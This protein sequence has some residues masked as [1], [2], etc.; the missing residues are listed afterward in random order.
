MAVVQSMDLT[1]IETA[2]LRLAIAKDDPSVRRAIDLYRVTQSESALK[3]ALLNVARETI[4]STLE[5]NDEED[6][7]EDEE[8][9]DEEDDNEEDSA[10][11]E[12]EEPEPESR[13]YSS[14]SKATGSPIKSSPV[15]VTTSPSKTTGSPA[16]HSTPVPKT[17]PLYKDFDY[18]QAED[19]SDDDDEDEEEEE[20][21]EDDDHH[22]KGLT[23]RAA[24][25]HV[26]PILVNE[27][28]KESIIGARDGNLILK[29]FASGNAEISA[30]LD[31]YDRTSN[32]A[33][34]VE[35]LQLIVANN[36]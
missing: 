30:A 15:K 2:A 3:Q 36:K 1:D 35:A 23:S 27:L 29:M 4:R 20:E 21:E 33:E 13:P 6:D 28:V 12:D 31:V 26:F 22:N 19:A 10:D 24:R 8:D 17:S 25:D 14:P 16:I 7:E 5:S 18:D 32:M 11:S 34:L 9:E